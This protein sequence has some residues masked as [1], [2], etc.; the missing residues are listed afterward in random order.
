M[1]VELSPE[2]RAVLKETE[3]L[4]S[5]EL[6]QVLLAETKPEIDRIVREIQGPNQP[7]ENTLTELRD[8]YLNVALHLPALERVD[9]DEKRR[10]AL[11][12]GIRLLATVQAWFG[13]Q[14]SSGRFKTRTVEEA[15]LASR[16]WRQ[17]LAV[18]G[19]HAFVFEP[20]IAWQFSDVNTTGTLKEEIRDLR[21]LIALAQQHRARLEAVKMPESFI[22]EG[23]NLLDQAEGR[24]LL[25]VLGF[26]SRDDALLLRNELLTYATLLGTEARAAGVNA[27]YDDEPV[28]RRFDAASFRNA[29]RR[30]KPRRRRGAQGAEG[31]EPAAEPAEPTPPTPVT[32]PT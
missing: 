5:L 26:R 31:E 20:E 1:A 2:L 16:P 12:D 19:N 30:I 27:C 18:F 25:A 28:R 32:E 7:V 8:L 24:D 29:I 15:V 14:E 13:E 21:T 6:F 9:Y 23:R 10:A 3:R 17:R 4:E 11:R 22:L